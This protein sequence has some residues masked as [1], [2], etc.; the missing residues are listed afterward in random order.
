MGAETVMNED[1]E[2]YKKEIA[3]IRKKERAEKQRQRRRVEKEM[4]E[5]NNLVKITLVVPKSREKII[6]DFAKKQG[7]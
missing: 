3:L 5:A 1:I 7:V 4:L 2:R 6:R